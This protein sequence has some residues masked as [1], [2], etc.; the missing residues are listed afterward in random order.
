MYT[1]FL[2]NCRAHNGLQRLIGRNS[3]TKYLEAQVKVL[4]TICSV[5]VAEHE[6]AKNGAAARWEVPAS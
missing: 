5:L 2:S 6:I 1:D 4:E 3:M